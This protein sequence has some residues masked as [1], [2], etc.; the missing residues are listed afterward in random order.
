MF[1]LDAPRFSRNGA[2]WFELLR[3][4][5]ATGTLLLTD[6]GVYD[7]CSGDDSFV[8]GLHGTLSVAELYRIKARMDKGKLNKARRGELYHA[9]PAGYVLDGKQ[10]RKDPD[11]HVQEAIGLVFAKFRELGTARQVAKALRAESE[12]AERFR[13]RLAAH[14]SRLQPLEVHLPFAFGPKSADP[15]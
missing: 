10:L 15:V 11:A 13:Q 7:A 6:E 9:A 4:L 12:H 5:R 2:E 1:G 3:W 8:L 14:R